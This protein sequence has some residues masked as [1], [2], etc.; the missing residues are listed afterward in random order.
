MTKWVCAWKKK[1]KNFNIINFMKGK[2]L[3]ALTNSESPNTH[4][5]DQLTWLDKE[6]SLIIYHACI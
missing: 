6:K 5:Q 3:V 2:L 1:K 4:P